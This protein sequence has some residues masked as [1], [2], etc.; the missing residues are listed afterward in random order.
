MSDPRRQRA[1]LLL[2]R[3]WKVRQS[4]LSF[5]TRSVAGAASRTSQVTVV[6][7]APAGRTEPDG[8][9]DLFGA[10]VGDGGAWPTP[11]DAVWPDQLAEDATIIVDEP[12]HATL[13]ILDQF[14][15]GHA[16]RAI[17]SGRADVRSVTPFAFTGPPDD[18]AADL[19]CLHVPI[20]RMAATHRHN[21]LGF[22]GYFLVLSDRT[23]S[24]DV[25][26]PTAMVA[27]LTA[28]FPGENVVVVED[29]TAAVWRGRVLRGVVPVYT[30]TD[31]WR[32]LAHARMTI[33]LA[34]GCIIARECIES[35]LFGTPI[36][37]PTQSTARAHAL[38][39]GGMT[40]SSYS[41]L[42]ACVTRLA[43]ES[44]RTTLSAD[45]R[46]YADARYGDQ[47]FFVDSVTRALGAPI[48]SGR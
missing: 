29:A 47:R 14:A 37:V 24:P 16:V 28:R 43:D 26:P 10:G 36:V 13:G 8:A 1:T 20:N 31:L 39:G 19:I 30:R 32:L 44:V 22:T 33:D 21:G 34:P 11:A 18:V 6:V 35:L 38:A 17:S 3:A 5:V 12:D 25:S 46:R 15:P 9:F 23:G 4:E 42:L 48:A 27:W 41:E 45:G 2:S 40:F 7:P